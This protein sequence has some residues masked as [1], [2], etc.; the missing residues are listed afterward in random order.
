LYG[1]KRPVYRKENCFFEGDCIRVCPVS[2]WKVKKT[3]FAVYIGGKVGRFPKFGIKIADF[4]YEKQ[5]PRIIKNTISCYNKIAEKGE[6]FGDA[7]E[8]QDLEAI[9]KEIL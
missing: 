1:N 5:I 7:L 8:R 4:V 9:K 6:R 3:G 2:A